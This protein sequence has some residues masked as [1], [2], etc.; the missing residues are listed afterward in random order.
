MRAPRSFSVMGAP[1]RVEQITF[2]GPSIS[3]A[4]ALALSGGSNPNMGDPEA[5][6]VFRFL[7]GEDGKETPV[8]YHLNMM[9]AGGYFL[10]QRFAMQDADLL[11]VGNARANQPSKLIQIIS[12]LFAP[13]VTVRAIAG[14]TGTSSTSN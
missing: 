8:V 1:G 3:L 9:K 6:F 12:Q 11:Y 14:G 2:T 7:P 4:Q 10:S 13:I 5:I